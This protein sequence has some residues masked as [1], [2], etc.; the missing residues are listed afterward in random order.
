MRVVV[1]PSYD[2][3]QTL[4][5]AAYDS[6]DL[7]ENKGNWESRFVASLYMR[8]SLVYCLPVQCIMVGVTSKNGLAGGWQ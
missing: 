7:R 4:L 5:R 1:V 2:R 8:R 3:P 6:R